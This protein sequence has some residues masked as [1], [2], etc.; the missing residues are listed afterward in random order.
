MSIGSLATE[1][2]GCSPTTSDSLLKNG[3]RLVATSIFE[4]LHC[5][6]LSSLLSQLTSLAKRLTS[7]AKRGPGE[8]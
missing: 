7:L 6:H 2:Y 5:P 3:D 8:W 4:F 1:H